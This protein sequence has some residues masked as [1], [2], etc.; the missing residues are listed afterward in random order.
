MHCVKSNIL[1]VLIFPG[2]AQT[3]YTVGEVENWTFI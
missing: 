1:L 2:S 3:H